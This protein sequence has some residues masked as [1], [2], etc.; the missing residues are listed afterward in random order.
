[1]SWLAPLRFIADT[2]LPARCPGCGA[3][4]REDHRFCADCWGALRF[5]GEPCCAACNLPFT[6]NRGR[7]ARC[8]ECLADPPRHGGIRAAVAYGDIARDLVLRLKYG[9][10]MAYADTAARHMARLVTPDIDLL[11]PVPL[12][13]WRIWSRGYNQSALLAQALGRLTATPCDLSAID[14]IKPTPP[15]GGLNRRERARAVAAAF[16][17]RPD[18]AAQ[19]AGKTI[20]LVDDV[21]TSGATSNA[22]VHQLLSAGAARIIILCWARVLKSSDLD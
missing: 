6:F 19:V 16:R 17:I 22:C 4:T 8:A 2:A 3:V 15:L 11:V 20:G 1:M 14:R 10:R 5:L 9:G 12:H 7:G 18:H 13:R 21:H